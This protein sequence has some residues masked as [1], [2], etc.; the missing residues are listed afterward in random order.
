MASGALTL[1]HDGLSRP[2]AAP[3][4]RVLSL[5]AGVQSTTLA[6][7]AARGDLEFPDCA[8]FADTGSEPASV[9]RHLEWLTSVLPFPVHTVSAG[10]LGAQLLCKT[11]QKNYP[12]PP[13]FVM[14]DDGKVGLT[15]RQCTQDFKI[16]PIQQKIR[17]LLEIKPRGHGPKS[18]VVEQWI[19]ISTDEITRLKTSSYRY[20]HMRHPLIEARLSRRDCLAWLAIRQ[21]PTPPKSACTFCPFHSDAMWQAMKLD[22]ADSF[23][24]A[25]AV[26][27]AIRANGVLLKGAPFLHRSCLP[28]SEVDFIGPDAGSSLFGVGNECDGVCFV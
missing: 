24:E 9:Y 22:D 19:G 16:R 5:G 8:I 21:Y 26:D 20:V 23:A 3:R 1:H 13:M 25:V 2:L 28:L 11:P 27:L 12:R 14:G 15:N 7:M 4:L 18:P 6:L 17:E 10:D